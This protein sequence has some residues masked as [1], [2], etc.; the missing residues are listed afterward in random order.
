M[1]LWLDVPSVSDI[2]TCSHEA[3]PPSN[4]SETQVED[5]CDHSFEGLNVCHVSISV[6]SFGHRKRQQDETNPERSDCRV[7][8]AGLMSGS[9]AGV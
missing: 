9:G 3:S 7:R 2:K 6:N 8:A 5:R 1:N 4:T